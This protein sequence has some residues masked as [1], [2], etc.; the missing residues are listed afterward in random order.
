MANSLIDGLSVLAHKGRMDLLN[1]LR[2]PARHFP[3][4]KDGD[5]EHDGACSALIAK[6]WG[7]AQP[8]ASRHL[9]L[10]VDAELLTPTRKKG[11][12]F[13]RRNEAGISKLQAAIEKRLR[14]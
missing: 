3:P 8:T 10:M 5:L 1:W 14:R 2:E 4:Q 12:T 13:Y 6:K 9:K 7:V 11:W